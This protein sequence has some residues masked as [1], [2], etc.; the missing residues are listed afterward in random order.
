MF[1][2]MDTS[3]NGTLDLKELRPLAKRL[4]LR[5][6]ELLRLMDA[7]VSGQIDF[8]EFKN[9]MGARRRNWPIAPRVGQ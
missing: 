2:S 8:T 1:D 7:D 6:E 4:G 5:P 3:R 9:Y